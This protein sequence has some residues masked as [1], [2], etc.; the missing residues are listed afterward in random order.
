MIARLILAALLIAAPLSRAEAAVHAQML[1]PLNTSVR[2]GESQVYSVRFLDAVNQ[3]A[4][5]EA[6]TFSNDACGWFQNGQLAVTVTTDAA[7]V[8]SATFTAVNQGITC[9]IN[10]S[11][12]VNVRFNVFTY[13]VAQ[14]YVDGQ[15]SPSEPRAGEEFTL[16]AGAYQ[17]AYPIYGSDVTARVLPG[18]ISATI[19]PASGNMGSS[20]SAVD[21]AVTPEDRIGDFAVEVAFRGVTRR[22]AFPAP[23]SPWQDMWWAGATENGWGMSVVQHR[24]LLFSVIYAYDG[25]GKPI[26]YVMPSGTWNEAKTAFT[27]ALYVPTGT[28]YS[29]YDA[30]KLVVNDSVGTATITF[31]SASNGT[32]DYVIG[33]VS[34]HKA[35][36]RQLFGPQDSGA[37]LKGL[38][39]M[40]WGGAAQ[41]GWGI[42]LLQQYKTLFGVWFT[43]D[44]NGKATWFVMPSGIWA[45]LDSY[46]GHIYRTT[47]SAWLGHAYDA[48]AL[49]AVDAGTFRVR[50]SGD[51]VT[52]DYAIDGTPGTMALMRQGF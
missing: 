38:G 52:F 43:Y 49:E 36:T 50:F 12:G 16:T 14:V 30:S 45:T 6:V 23:A 33:G 15:V 31:T 2:G 24:D 3:P 25:A 39:D 47:G 21:F 22:F 46:S 42:A 35:V 9:W 7:G 20:G 37:P 11:A 8:A 27:G 1:T 19:A 40:W 18:T 13:S 48:N 26:W 51:N 4:V 44:A 29:A 17:G 41:N 32:L 5:G 34:G 10:A 28:P